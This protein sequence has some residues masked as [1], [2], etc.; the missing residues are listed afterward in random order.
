MLI[1]CM[2]LS[3]VVLAEPIR[4]EEDI[5][6][7]LIDL[8]FEDDLEDLLIDLEKELMDFLSEMDEDS[9]LI[10][11][12]SEMNAASFISGFTSNQVVLED[13][14]AEL[15]MDQYLNLFGYDFGDFNVYDSEVDPISNRHYKMH[16]MVDGIPVYGSEAIV[17]T[18][19]AGH[20]Y[21]VNN[22]KY[23]KNIDNIKWQAQFRLTENQ[24]LTH[25]ESV[26]G[27]TVD[28]DTYINQPEFEKYVYPFQGKNYPVYL[29]SLEF[30]QPYP[31]Y[32]KVF[33]D[34]RNGKV[35][36]YYNGLADADGPTEGRG[37]GLDGNEKDINTYLYQGQYYLYDDT[38]PMSGQI[39]TYDINH[40][41]ESQLPGSYAVDADNFFNAENQKASVDAHFYAGVTYDYYYNTH[42]RDSFDGQGSSIIS[43]VHFGN[44]YNN[45][46]WSGSQMVYGDGDGQQM[47]ALCGSL[48]V[49][50]H[51]LAHAVTQHSANLEYRN[52][53]GALNES[54]SDVFGSAVEYHHTGRADWWVLAED[55][56]T[57]NVP[58]DSM[59][60]MKDP[61]LGNQ[62]G[63][64]D[65]YV[66]TTQDN[67]GVHINSGIP[68]RAYYL[69]ASEIGVSKAERIYYR[70]LTVYL[71]RTSNFNDNRVALLQ[72]AA[73]LYGMNSPEYIAIGN[74]QAAVGIGQPISTG[75]SLKAASLSLSQ[76]GTSDTYTI[77]MS[78][79]ANNK[80]TSLILLEG[81]SQVAQFALSENQAS[82]QT[83]DKVFTGK[84]DGVY[85][86]QA[87]V[88]DGVTSLEG[89]SLQVTVNTSVASEQWYNDSVTYETAHNYANNYTK[90]LTYTKTGASKVAIHF[91]YFRFEEN[92]DFVYILDKNDQVIHTLTGNQDNTWVEV[93]GDVMK[94]KIE[95]DYSVTD[96]GFSIDGG[97][98]YATGEIN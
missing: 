63:H 12:D 20:V 47:S 60:N 33:V 5:N 58:G 23:G 35:I 86:Y 50:A 43:T 80:A 1:I 77:H 95:T 71:T 25:A 2:L 26:L 93:E 31:G 38:K 17:H 69:A 56:W 44:N 68:N 74:S 14:Y 16:Y 7:I 70:A 11:Y 34:A 66:N 97:K 9:L 18:N 84:A 53:S 94:I 55:I 73:D 48:D 59:R 24:A 41:G 4:N 8:M 85:T 61:S 22:S 64:M 10:S 87:S 81:G 6:D 37:V 51:E 46:F 45:A 32:F 78:V 36:D 57:P 52:Q 42:G 49:V 76:T 98:Y 30:L 75:P 65:D 54:Y 89:G 83:H 62:P 27:F 39:R 90:T 29:V 40:G 79:P 96:W 15:F 21:A 82:E 28:E 3:S 13:M 19:S 91:D 72:S 88:S 67:G 92:Y